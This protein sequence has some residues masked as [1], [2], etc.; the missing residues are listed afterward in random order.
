MLR[1]PS[2]DS[3][4]GTAYEAKAVVP[5]EKTNITTPSIALNTYDDERDRLVKQMVLDEI[6][7]DKV[8]FEHSQEKY[9]YHEEG[10]W[11]I[12]EETVG[13]DPGSGVRRRLSTLGEWA[14]SASNST[15]TT[16]YARKRTKC[17]MTTCAPRD[18]S[19]RF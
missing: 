4:N 2:K 16:P 9:I 1:L 3:G 13:V 6:P 10:A 7:D 12:H 19:P 5:I 11:I 17:T 15:K 14:R 8:I 18:R